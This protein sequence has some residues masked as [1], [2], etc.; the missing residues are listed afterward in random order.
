MKVED[1]SN[2][3]RGDSPAQP[4]TQR[5]LRWIPAV[6]M[7]IFIFIASGTPGGELPE[8]GKFNLIVKKGG[9]M[10]GYALLAIACFFATY[11]DFK[12]VTRSAILSMCISIVYAASD[13]FH[14]S[15]TPGRFPSVIDVGIDTAGAIIGVGIAAFV[16]KVRSEK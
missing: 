10:T 13:E 16:A 6:I 15:F 2:A 11:G 1:S 9:H 5:F 8:F 7:M 4:F 14:Q 12:N 3:Q